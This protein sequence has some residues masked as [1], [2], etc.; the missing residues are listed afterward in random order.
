V[1]P[2]RT[3]RCAAARPRRHCVPHL[4]RSRARSSW[5]SRTAS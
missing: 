4:G 5:R 3:L 1:H 2:D